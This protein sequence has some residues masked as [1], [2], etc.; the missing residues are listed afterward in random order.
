VGLS[1]AIHL[2]EQQPD[3]KVVIFEKGA[4]PS[5]ASTRNAGFAC[6]GSISELSEDLEQHGEA[7]V[8]ALVEKRWRGLQRLRS[9]VGDAGLELLQ[10]G[11]YEFFLHQDKND[12]EHYR[13]QLAYFN[14]QLSGIIG[15]EQVFSVA[16]ERIADFG[17]SGVEHLV[18]N[19][20]EAQIHTGAMMKALLAKA[21]SVD[22]DIYNGMAIDALQSGHDGVHLQLHNG[23]TLKAQRVLVA[24]NGFVNTLLGNVDVSPARNQVLI[25]KPIA[26]LRFEGTFHYDRGYYYFRNLGN[27]VLFGGAR[28]TDPVT[29][30]THHFGLTTTIQNKLLRMLDQVILPGQQ[31]EVEHWWSGILGVGESRKPMVQKWDERVTIAVRLGGMGVAIGSLVGEEGAALVLA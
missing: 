21:R 3:L 26:G 22:V 14:K 20:A 24:T 11:G 28:N 6:F 31:Y 1:A 30:T 15:N 29:E 8:F 18:F 19:L 27:R 16:D 7:A 9:R 17:F 23:W 10:Y 2:K 13:S 25:T 5:G 12:F 4:I